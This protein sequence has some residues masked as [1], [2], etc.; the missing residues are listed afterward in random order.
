[1]YRQL[2]LRQQQTTL[3]TV[4]ST[5]RAGMVVTIPAV[6]IATNEAKTTGQI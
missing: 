2:L 5:I 3:T 4:K 1:M 6:I